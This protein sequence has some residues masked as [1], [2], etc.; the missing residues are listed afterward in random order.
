MSASSVFSGKSAEPTVI[1]PVP[2]GNVVVPADE[3]A[4]PE[5]ALLEAPPDPA[6]GQP[7]ELLLAPVLDGVGVFPPELPL[8]PHAV[9]AS[10]RLLSAAPN[11]SA[12]FISL[13]MVFR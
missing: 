11:T 7:L 2:L 12:R 4:L 5:A 8:L 6:G 13:L 10:I 1:D 3:D 9:T